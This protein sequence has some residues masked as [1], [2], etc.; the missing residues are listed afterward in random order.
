[1]KKYGNEFKVGLFIVVCVI[2]LVAVTFA[3]GKVNVKKEGYNLYVTFDEIAGLGKKAP[4]MLNGF[5]VGKVEDIQVSDT[6]NSTK[7]TLKLWLDRK[8]KVRDCAEISIKTMGLMGEKYIQIASHNGN[9][10]KD[11]STVAGKP[12]M[13]IDSLMDQTKILAEEARK[14]SANLNNTVEGNKDEIAV[15]IKNLETTSKNVE[16]MTADLKANPW[17]LLSKPKGK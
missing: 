1:M 14:L 12:Y 16:E 9:F 3:T 2:G 11:G 15:I 5:E 8:A 10:I 17:K 4:V 13:D 7:I 6:E